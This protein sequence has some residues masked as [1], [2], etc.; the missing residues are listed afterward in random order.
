MPTKDTEWHVP[1]VLNF[2]GT[3]NFFCCTIEGEEKILK[4]T[5]SFQ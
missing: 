5:V 2:T 1:V 3:E 4:I